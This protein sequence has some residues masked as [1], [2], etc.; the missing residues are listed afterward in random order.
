M[1]WGH[2]DHQDTDPEDMIGKIRQE[3]NRFVKHDLPALT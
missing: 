3:W 2:R 1:R